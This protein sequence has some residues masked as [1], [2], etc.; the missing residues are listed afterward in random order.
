M[1][2][3]QF[4]ANALRED[5]SSMLK[6]IESDPHYQDLL[7][8][9]ETTLEWQDLAVRAIRNPKIPHVYFRLYL[10]LV[11]KWPGILTGELITDFSSWQLREL[12]GWPSKES[13][14]KFINDLKAIGAILEYDSGSPEKGEDGKITRLGTIRGDP[15][16]MPYPELWRL[17]ETDQRKKE[18]EAQKNR[19]AQRTLVL[20]CEK[21]GGKIRY[22]LLP[23]CKDCGHKHQAILNIPASRVSIEPE[24]PGLAADDV[25]DFTLDLAECGHEKVHQFLG[26]D[27]KI[28]CTVCAAPWKRSKQ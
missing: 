17:S 28:H 21:C 1:S 16:I 15:D 5:I 18:R 11:E 4:T 2:T 13:T 8:K 10:A 27:G 20:A 23:T 6:E 25:D 14:T 19:D 24:K 26:Q 9:Y 7:G 3:Q 12:A 22:D